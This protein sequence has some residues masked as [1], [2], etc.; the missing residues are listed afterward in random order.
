MF[1]LVVDVLGRLIDKAKERNVIRGFTVVRDRVDISHLQFAD[2]TL[3]FMEADRP[4][5]LDFLKIL[6]VFHSF[7][8]LR[9]NLSKS[10]LLGINTDAFLLQE[11]AELSGC[12]LGDWPIK[13]LGLPL[14]GNPRQIHFWDL[15][16]TKVAKRLDD[17]KRSFL[18]RGGRLTVIHSVLESLP[19]YYLSLF[20]APMGVLHSM[21]KLMRDFL[22]DGGD[23][24]GGEHLVDWEVICL[25]KDRVGLGVGNMGKRNRSLLMIWLWRFPKEDQSLWHKVI[26]SK[27]GLHPNLWDTKVDYKG[28]LRSPWKAISSLYAEFNQLV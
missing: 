25:A 15:M 11:L 2:D 20:K 24:V 4:F 8:G 14:G 9:V 18:S 28:T 19:I 6:E 22:W 5:F 7:L 23:M 26:K 3:L 27:F 12:E 17:W 13:Y 1:T 21:E 16:V 10:I